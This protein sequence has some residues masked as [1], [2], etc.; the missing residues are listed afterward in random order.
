MG[1]RAGMGL[2]MVPVIQ[3]LITKTTS[4]SNRMPTNQTLSIGFQQR[5]FEPNRIH[6]GN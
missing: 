3:N 5:R 6:S 4:K 1:K 2:A